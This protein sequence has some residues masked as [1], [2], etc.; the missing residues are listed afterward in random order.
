M[1]VNLVINPD[2]E[3]EKIDIFI[4]EATD[5]IFE[6][7][8]KLNKENLTKLIGIKDDKKY[9]IDTKNIF[10]LFSIN[11]KIYFSTNENEYLSNKK[12]YELEEQL[13]SN[14][15]IRISNQEIINVDYISHLDFSFNGN[16]KVI[17]KNKYVSYVNR[18]YIKN[19]KILLNI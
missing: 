1:K 6:I 8:G 11:K 14:K 16:I 15:F 18:S 13:N 12:L 5:E 9:I 2:I 19:F 10:R 7:I 17:F 4:K 3:E